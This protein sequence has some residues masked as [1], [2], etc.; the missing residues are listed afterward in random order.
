MTLSAYYI[1]LIGYNNI[2][3]N[4][5]C[6]LENPD[7]WLNIINKG[8]IVILDPPY[9][10]LNNENKHYLYNF[11]REEQEKLCIFI[12]KL[13]NK[14]VKVITFNGNT[15]FIKDLYKNFNFKLIESKTSLNKQKP[16]KELLIY[17]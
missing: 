11:D 3:I 1:Y 7:Y 4:N 10:I 13:I 14:N 16:Y 5:I 15:L 6:L 2:N 8:D 9:D 12:N 17:N